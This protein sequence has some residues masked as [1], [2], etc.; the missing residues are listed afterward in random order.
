MTIQAA[1]EMHQEEEVGVIP[2]VCPNAMHTWVSRDPLGTASAQAVSVPIS[3]QLILLTALGQ[4][5]KY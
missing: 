4:R 3:K 2:E 1:I 5:I